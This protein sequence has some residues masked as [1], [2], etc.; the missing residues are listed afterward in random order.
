MPAQ[1][2]ESVLAFVR[3]HMDNAAYLAMGLLEEYRKGFGVQ[4]MA[5]AFAKSLAR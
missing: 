4:L 1:T 3:W 5:R 2:A